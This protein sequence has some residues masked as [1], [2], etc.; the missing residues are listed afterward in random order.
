MSFKIPRSSELE[1]LAFIMTP[2]MSCK[3]LFGAKAKNWRLILH[4][5][6]LVVPQANVCHSCHRAMVSERVCV[7]VRGGPGW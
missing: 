3:N 7:W 6:V 4:A 5:A 2:A 1:S